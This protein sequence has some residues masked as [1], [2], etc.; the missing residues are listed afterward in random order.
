MSWMTLTDFN[1]NFFLLDDQ[2]FFICVSQLANEL[3]NTQN[4]L[5]DLD[6]LKD[7]LYPVAR[8]GALLFAVMRSLASVR[9]EYQFT[10][11]YFLQLFDEAV[12]GELPADY[13]HGEDEE[14]VSILL[15]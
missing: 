7:E 4:I 15:S 8:R 11:T 3:A 5:S 12:G 10:L 9:H 1:V 6:V 14:D 13:G 2:S